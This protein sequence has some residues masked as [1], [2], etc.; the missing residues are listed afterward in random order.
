MVKIII[1][2]I[3]FLTGCADTS[4]YRGTSAIPDAANLMIEGGTAYAAGDC[5]KAIKIYIS[6]LQYAPDDLDTM[7]KIAR[8]SYLLDDREGAIAQYKSILRIAPTSRAAHYNLLFIHL[9]LLIETTSGVVEN[10][11]ARSKDEEKLL[12]IATRIMDAV[13]S[14]LTAPPDAR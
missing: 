10:V 9:S 7:L 14:E 5:K 2:F 12:E 4:Q 8:C 13:N 1:V 3:L 11:P 6:L